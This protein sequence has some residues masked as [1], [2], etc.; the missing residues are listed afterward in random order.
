[1]MSRSDLQNHL[2]RLR[3][4]QI[5]AAQLL[6]VAPRTVRRWL[7]GE[8]VPGP[9]E[10]ALRAWLR[11][12]EHKLVWRPDTLAIAEDDQQPIAGHRRQAIEV[13][14][15]LQRVEA[16]G[17][18]RLPW[19]VDRERCRAILGS[20]MEVT[21][22]RLANGDFS[23]ASYTCKNALPDLQ[24]DCELIEDAVFCIAKEMKKEAAIPVTL[25]YMDGPNF[26]GPDGKFGSM[27]HEEF[28][29]NEAAIRRACQL[30]GKPNIYSL[31]IREGTSNSS[32]EFLWNDPELRRECARRPP[33]Q[34]AT[35]RRI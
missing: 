27:R 9:A 34:P 5:E 17:G 10:Q 7:E 18:P 24:R 14:D 23:L 1:M 8:E 2:R 35:V 11:L 15:A 3:I 28:L 33:D 6:G 20:M 25:V 31:A 13:S 16:R 12:H 22:D 29:S 21:F 4:S 19:H 30:V 32:G 26:V